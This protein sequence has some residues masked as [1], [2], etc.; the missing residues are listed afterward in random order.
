MPAGPRRRRSPAQAREE[1][2]RAA[3]ALLDEEGLAAVTVEALA[4]RSGVAK[5]TIYRTWP[6]AATVAVDAAMGEVERAAPI[7]DTGTGRRDLAEIFGH[8]EEL[9]DSPRGRHLV[10]L[11]GRAQVDEAVAA[12][13]RDRLVEPRRAVSRAII[14][15]AIARGELPETVQVD[16]MIDLLVGTLY[17]RRMTGGTSDQPVA[18]ALVDVVWEGAVTASATGHPGG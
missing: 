5:T 11:V 3:L 12:A 1:V 6:N 16:A 4:D 18:A 2:V 15:R 8:L 17:W 10:E 9:L 13:L 14:E 7:P